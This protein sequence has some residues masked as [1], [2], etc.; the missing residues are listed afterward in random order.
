MKVTY[1]KET[2]AALNEIDRNIKARTRMLTINSFGCKAISTLLKDDILNYLSKVRSE[3]IATA[4]VVGYDLADYELGCLAR[5]EYCSSIDDVL[6][7]ITA[8]EE[9]IRL[10]EAMAEDQFKHNPWRG[11]EAATD[12]A[13]TAM[14]EF[15][16]VAKEM[17]ADNESIEHE[18]NKLIKGVSH[19]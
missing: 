11:L 19:E 8:S 12:R 2:Q 7:N 15:G 16:R 6:S 4:T 10:R 13:C 17:G 3:T 14:R 18:L 5:N 9:R 1:D